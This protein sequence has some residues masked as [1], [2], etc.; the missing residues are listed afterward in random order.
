MMTMTRRDFLQASGIVAAG[1]IFLP[2]VVKPA[3]RPLP[4]LPPLGAFVA[5][6]CERY[7]PAAIEL[8]NEPEISAEDAAGINAAHVLGGYGND[9]ESYGQAVAAVWGALQ[10]GW[11]STWLVA[12]SMM[13]SSTL[14]WGRA[15]SQSRRRWARVQA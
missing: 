15:R 3:A 10:D 7:Q 1:T 11:Y 8:W 9:A 13:D 6:L 2:Y 14:W 4:Y 12:G 5:A